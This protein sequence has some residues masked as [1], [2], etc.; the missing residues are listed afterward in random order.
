[1]SDAPQRFPLQW[2]KHRPRKPANRRVRGGFTADTKRI[3]LS[4]AMDRLET[5]LE[6]LGA[7]YPLVSTNIEPRLDGRPKGGLSAPADPG[8]CVYFQLKGESFALA[9]DT[10]TE[11]SQNLAGLAE[12]IK[13]TRMIERY[14][15]ASAAET[16]QAFSALPPPAP[17]EPPPRPWH[18]VLG[19]MPQAASKEA[20]EAIYR[21]RARGAH[22]DAGGPAGAMAELN[23]AR[24][25]ALKAIE[26]AR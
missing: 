9:I 17:P 23:R 10:F 3:S 19:I 14:G 5:E 16:L 6:R 25:E 18:E 11:V 15:V 2:P 20:V 12:H 21:V 24:D 22:P 1:M 13:A 4:D 26:G 7:V 8:V